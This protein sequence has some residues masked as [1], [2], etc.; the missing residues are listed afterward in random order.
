MQISKGLEMVKG[1]INTASRN[2]SITLMATF[3][4]T[5]AITAWT[6]NHVRLG[7]SMDQ[8][9]R[10]TSDFITDAVPPAIFL[11]EPMFQATWVAA[12][13]DL[14]ADR[15]VD[16]A[17][18]EKA[19]RERLH[20]WR[21]ADLPPNIR[22]Q[23]ETK[24]VP[25]GDR[26]WKQVREQLLPAGETGDP[27][28]INVAHDALEDIFAE[29]RKQIDAMLVTARAHQ[30]ELHQSSTTFSSWSTWGLFAVALLLGTQLVWTM[31]LL[32]RHVLTP[33]GQ[34]AETM[35]R[36]G[37]GELQA[38]RTEVHRN[39]EIG[40]M[41][42]AIEVFRASAL[43]KVEDAREQ[44]AVVEA[45]STA[46]GELAAGR[47]DAEIKTG[48]PDEYEQLR[49]AYNTTVAQLGNLIREVSTSARGV[50]GG[51]SDILAA[52]DDLASRN[53]AQ[54]GTIEETAA[55]MRQVTQSV[56][57]TAE[58]T[59]EVRETMDNTHREVTSG[60][61]TVQRTVAAMSE[62]E[63]SSHEIN[64]I[65]S[66]IEGIAFQT[67]LLALNAGVE[68]ARAGDA[69][70]GFAVVATEVRALA[71]RSSDAAREISTRISTS[72]NR[73]SEGV[74]LVAETGELLTRMVDRIT[75][76]NSQI[77]QIASAAQQQASNLAQVNVSMGD[78][79]RVTQQN[80]AMVEQTTAA[81]RSLAQESDQMA[82]LVSRFSAA[83]NVTSITAPPRAQARKVGRER[84]AA[85]RFDGQL[86]LAAPADQ[87]DA[88]WSE[89]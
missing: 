74:L 86:A 8:D 55:A 30:A 17:K 38:G 18:Q 80:A 46:L 44:E 11:I 62:I 53:A 60:G 13:P 3:A 20:S 34:T 33:L 78:M 43:Q 45:L 35:T 50:S 31:R 12:D 15:R 41:T 2:V 56:A 71:Q 59:A 7:G 69:G 25:V 66:V 84:P 85:A 52:S 70:K 79:D 73:V 26:F 4:I 89:F 1:S 39:D 16:L 77:G 76:I 19:Y 10:I 82:Q 21:K 51:A 6:L 58:R 47:L 9:N 24:L 72:T 36:M 75:A 61:E 68:A 57:E 54:A 22:D 83:G 32:R 64:Q 49:L 65:I 48:F 40:D 67:N 29:H 87:P 23:F 5:I 28:R 27:A 14:T 37:A 88:D 81:A 63:S 42:R